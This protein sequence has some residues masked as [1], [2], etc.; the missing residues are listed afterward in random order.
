M[1]GDGKTSL[2][3]G[4]GIGLRAQLRQRDL[5][6]AL[7]PAAVPG[8]LD[9]RPDRRR[10]RCRSTPTTRGRSAASPA[11]PSRSRPAACATSTRTSRP[12]TPTSTACRCSGSSFS[13]TVAIDRVHR[14]PPG[15]SSTTSPTPTSAARRSSTRASARRPA[16]DHPVRRV[17]HPRQPRPVAVPRRHVR[18]RVAQAREQRRCSSPRS[19]PLAR[20][21]T[22]SARRSRT[23]PTNYNLG[24]L[25]AFDPMLDY[26]YAEFDVRHR[27]IVAGIWE[28]PLFRNSEGATK[29]L[30]GGWQLNWIFTAR[31]GH[32]FTAVRLHERRSASACAPTTRSAS[33]RTPPS[34]PATGNPNEFHAAR[35][36][37][38]SWPTA[39]GYVNPITG[40]SDFGPYP[41]DMTEARR[42]PRPGRLER[43]PEPHQALPLRRPLRRAAALRGVQRVQPRE[44]VRGHRR[45]PTSAA[46]RRSPASR[47]T[48]ARPGGRW[49]T[50]SAA[51]RSPRSSSS[52]PDNLRPE[53]SR[54]GAA[55][56]PPLFCRPVCYIRSM[57][58]PRFGLARLFVARRRS[59]PPPKRGAPSSA[60]RRRGRR[61]GG[62]GRAAGAARG[63]SPQN[64]KRRGPGGRRAATGRSAR[65]WPRAPRIS[66]AHFMLFGTSFTR[67]ERVAIKDLGSQ[68]GQ[69]RRATVKGRLTA[70][71]ETSPRRPGNGRERAARLRAT[72][73]RR[74]GAG[75]RIPATAAR[76]TPGSYANLTRVLKEDEG[77]ARALDAARPCATRARSSWSGRTCS[78]ARLVVR[79]FAAPE[80]RDRGVAPGDHV[81]TAFAPHRSQGGRDRARGSTSPTRRT[82]STST[83]S[84]PCSRSRSWIRSSAGAGQQFALDRSVPTARE[85]PHHRS[86]RGPRNRSG[87]H[88]HGLRANRLS[89]GD[90]AGNERVCHLSPRSKPN[91]SNPAAPSNIFSSGDEAPTKPSPDPHQRARENF[92]PCAIQPQRVFD[93]SITPATDLTEKWGQK[94]RR[95]RIAHA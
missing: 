92:D 25:D 80:L 53:S 51:S 45:T 24:Y 60:T 9:R 6:R 17:Q 35:P 19:T 52:D 59:R 70:A 57:F 49:A 63:H 82:A 18:P 36:R 77:Y 4:Y 55:R 21:R 75:L 14:A 68:V 20:P 74:S 71:Y 12:P 69:G 26:G 2:R 22:T 27:V 76:A 29:T 66:V 89:L 37:R 73:A 31:S 42:V 43:R 32:P 87:V 40:N 81:A 84:R 30:L 44:H 23:R 16:P 47:A 85:I 34:G 91:Y 3:G 41:A 67:E 38:R 90:D 13:N 72:G 15:A 46:S 86:R 11:S 88:Q 79:H 50:A 61:R 93:D 5:Q 7:Q 58:C 64:S 95:K 39:G 83:R 65:A 1:N 78:G 62:E 28:L 54:G 56:L 94:I 10:R 8:R 48:D 33:T